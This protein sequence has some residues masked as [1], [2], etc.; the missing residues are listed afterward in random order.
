MTN[1][2]VVIILLVVIAGIA[3]LQIFLSKKE[4]KW[5]G[6][7]LPAISLLISILTV[8]GIVFFSAV[9]STSGSVISE[10]GEVIELVESL[11]ENSGD[12]AST[13]LSAILIFLLSNIPTVILLGIYFACRQRLRRDKQIERMNIQDLE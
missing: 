10:N 12:I 5:L 7:I 6:L 3:A 4:S 9:N 2:I 13:V 11:S 1:I 8:L